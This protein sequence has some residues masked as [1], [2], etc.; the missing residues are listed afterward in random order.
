MVLTKM[1]EEVVDPAFHSDSRGLA[2]K[3][4]VTKPLVDI[5]ANFSSDFHSVHVWFIAFLTH[6][7]SPCFGEMKLVILYNVAR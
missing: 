6:Y 4:F 7:G 2:T 3:G 1:F 5:M